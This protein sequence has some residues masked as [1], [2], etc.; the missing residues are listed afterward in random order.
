MTR[1][2]R[3][4]RPARELVDWEDVFAN[5]VPGDV[6]S[7]L[8]ELGVEVLRVKGEEA[9]ARCPAHLKRTGKEDRHPS[10]SVNLDEGYFGCFSCGFKGRFV[11]LVEEMLGVDDATAA[12]WVRERGGIERVR[13]VLSRREG[14]LLIDPRD[15]TQ[16]INE[17]SLSLYTEVPEEEAEKRGISVEALTARGVLWDPETKRWI[18]PIREPYTNTLLGWQEKN[19]KVFL[20]QPAE[21]QKGLTLFG[22]N[23]AQHER[24]KVLVESPLDV[25]RAVDAGYENFV[26]SYGV[27]VSNEQMDLILETT[28]VLIVG[29]DN[30][31]IDRD[32]RIA[33]RN[34]KTLYAK[35]IILRFMDYSHTEAKDPGEM[36]D[37][38]LHKAVGNAVS[39]ILFKT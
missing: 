29:L 1:K 21:V 16:N 38:E 22:F 18:T 28:D 13:K 17:A 24:T 34:M 36:D 31:A 15:T 27:H 33:N 23:E 2:R 3:R 11:H 26:A 6:M 19:K 37:A 9:E 7:C 35:R 32:A 10:F 30:P 20:N 5:P 4:T 14:G 12:A 8:D 39:S 25:C